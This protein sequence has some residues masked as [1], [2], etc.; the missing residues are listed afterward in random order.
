MTL[1]PKPFIKWAGGK[2]QLL[3]I[4]TQHLPERAAD[5]VYVEPFV[6]GGALLF[7]LQPAMSIIS[8]SNPEVVNAYS[9]LRDHL[10]E[11]LVAMAEHRNEESYYYAVRAQNPLNLSSVERASRF[12]FL[13]RTCFNGLY[14][15]NK[16]GQFNVPFGRYKNPTLVDAD[17]LRAVSAYLR[18]NQ[19][20]ICSNDFRLTLSAVMNACQGNPDKTDTVFVYLDP[21]YHGTFTGYT[22]RGFGAQDHES[23]AAWYASLNQVG[24]RVLLSNSNTDLIRNLYRDFEIVEVEASRNINRDGSKRGKTKCEVLVKNY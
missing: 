9:V 13:N 20:V 6:G 18:S 4:L 17:N 8:D 5:S 24:C 12:L 22:Q 16:D 7:H 14:R 23:L 21:P 3:P 15:V 10:E 19:G 1:N 11:L 2:R